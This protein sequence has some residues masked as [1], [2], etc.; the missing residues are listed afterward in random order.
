MDV[1]KLKEPNGGFTLTGVVFVV[2]QL[3]VFQQPDSFCQTE[4]LKSIDQTF[5]RT[6]AQ[7]HT[8]GQTP[9][10]SDTRSPWQYC[11]DLRASGALPCSAAAGA[12]RASD[13]PG[14]GESVSSC[15]A[16]PP[17]SSRERLR[18]SAHPPAGTTCPRPAP[19]P[20]A[21]QRPHGFTSVSTRAF[22]YCC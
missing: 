18:H 19:T 17:A 9:E 2:S 1:W 11:T 8:D 3:A 21:L 4:R 20:P 16:S 13:C 7:L 5:D 22:M 6:A 10:T 12:G 15:P 14:T